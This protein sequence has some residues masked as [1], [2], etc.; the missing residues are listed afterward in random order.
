MVVNFNRSPGNT[1]RREENVRKS[2][3]GKVEG[4]RE[5]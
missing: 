5:R 4:K 2:G 1:S 3:E